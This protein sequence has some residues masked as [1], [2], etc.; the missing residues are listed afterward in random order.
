[1]QIFGLPLEWC[2]EHMICK[3]VKHVGRV[4]EVKLETK[5]GSTLRASRIR[6]EINLQEPLKTGQ[7]IRIDRE[8]LWLNFCYERL[9]HF[10]YFCGKLG[11][12]AMHCNDFPFDEAKLEGKEKMSYS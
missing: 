10:C 11:H 9:S 5:E 4:L 6:I 3:A 7:L 12:Y 8:T 1:V 2:F